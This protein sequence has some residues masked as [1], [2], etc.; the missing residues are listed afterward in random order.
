MF[1]VEADI[2]Y[3]SELEPDAISV[4]CNQGRVNSYANIGAGVLT[5]GAYTDAQAALSPTCF[6]MQYAIADLPGLPGLASTVLSPL[7]SQ[8]TS[9]LSGLKNC[10][11]ITTLNKTALE[12][13][14]GFTLFGGP[15]GPIAPGAIQN[16]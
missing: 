14:P 15:T 3:L 13:C 4:G 7:I 6:G 8:L 11:P 2:L 12:A 16:Y 5:S 9:S 1:V 10:P